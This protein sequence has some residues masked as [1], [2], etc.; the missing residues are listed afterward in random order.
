[1]LF[2]IYG[3]D[4]TDK[5]RRRL[6]WALEEDPKT[7][8]KTKF[9]SEQQH[10][11]RMSGLAAGYASI[12][13]RDFSKAPF[14]NPYPKPNYWRA[15]ARIVNTPKEDITQTH[16]IALKALI[17]NSVK[18]FT[19][20]YTRAAQVALR[21]ALVEF[22]AK[23]SDSPAKLALTTMPELLRRHNIYL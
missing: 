20:F 16:L 6:G 4:N 21:T 13:L 9:I 18:R 2:G 19:E 8:E 17:E 1:M 7:G 10:N 15:L 23:A 3:K 5:G 11:D 14:P 22:P 12:S